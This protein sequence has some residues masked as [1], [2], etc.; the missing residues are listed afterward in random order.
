MGGSANDRRDVRKLPSHA[1]LAKLLIL[2]NDADRRMPSFYARLRDWT[3]AKE[4]N[5]VEFE[6]VGSNGQLRPATSRLYPAGREVERQLWFE[7]PDQLRVEVAESG[8]TIRVGVRTGQHW[9]RWD[10]WRGYSS[11]HGLEELPTVLDPVLLVPARLIGHLRLTPRGFGTRLQRTVWLVDAQD[12]LAGGEASYRL[13]FDAEHGVLLRR[14]SHINERCVR[15]TAALR[16]E[17]AVPIDP[18]KFEPF[19]PLT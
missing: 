6:R 9:W 10:H 8:R 7:A 1:D 3:H 12:R 15:E 18:A 11:G 19:V 16:T 17:F 5:V 2:L 13:E 14:S 4:S